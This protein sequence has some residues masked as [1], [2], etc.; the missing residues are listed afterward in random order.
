MDERLQSPHSAERV[1]IERLPCSIQLQADY[2]V[3][4][5]IPSVSYMP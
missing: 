2:T 1:H 3:E 5:W 4:S